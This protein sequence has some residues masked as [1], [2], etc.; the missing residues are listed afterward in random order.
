MG[1]QSD[2]NYKRD[3][4][5]TSFVPF[6]LVGIVFVFIFVITLVAVVKLAVAG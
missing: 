2:A 5:Q 3:F 4:A 6:L 1:V